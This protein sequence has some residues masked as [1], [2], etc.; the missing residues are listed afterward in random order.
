[1]NTTISPSVGSIAMAGVALTL[2]L[3][4]APGG[5]SVGLA[6]A[7]PPISPVAAVITILESGEVAE[8]SWSGLLNGFIGTPSRPR[9]YDNISI[10]VSGTG[11]SGGSVKIQGSNDAINWADVS[12]APVTTSG[13]LGFFAALNTLPKHIRPSVTAGDSTTDLLV[14]ARFS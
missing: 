6:G 13:G 10:Q 2:G 1:V 8:V 12:S 14:V 7:A 3:V 5:A 11:G 9:V 4:L